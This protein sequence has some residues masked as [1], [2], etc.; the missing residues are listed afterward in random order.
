MKLISNSD[1]S[2]N[3]VKGKFGLDKAIQIDVKA[4]E[5]FELPVIAAECYLKSHKRILSKAEETPSVEDIAEAKAT[6]T[7]EELEDAELLSDGDVK[8]IAKDLG[9][10]FQPNISRA[11]LIDRICE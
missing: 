10:K 11:K 7:R 2:L 4:G 1:F 6:P 8:Q 3:I 5:I 9:I